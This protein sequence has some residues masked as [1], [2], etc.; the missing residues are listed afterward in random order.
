MIRPINSEQVIYGVIPVGGR[1]TRLRNIIGDVPKV[2]TRFEG[3][4][5]LTYSLLS[6][7]KIGLNQL[8]LITTD[9]THK[10]IIKFVKEF[11]NNY[12]IRDIQINVINANKKGTAKA[13]HYVSHQI[14][15]P[16]FY[17]NG[18][19][20]FYPQIL[21]EIYKEFIS[22]NNLIAVVTGSTKDVAP[23]HPHFVINK[24]CYLTEV[25]I[26]PDIKSST[27][28][29]M[30][31]AIFS[32]EIFNYLEILPENSMTMEAL[33]LAL[34]DGKYVY[35]KVYNNFWYHLA[36]PADIGEYQRCLQEI[37]RIQSILEVKIK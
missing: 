4:E 32:P 15:T 14:K 31:T 21:Q 9:H 13:T 22:N 18:D 27:L 16:F 19:I 10:D 3:I 28:C 2:L 34:N 30:E 36:E 25:C 8:I 35:V 37:R 20:I 6:L 23:T 33:N 17:T 11:K 1:G 7:T 24:D 5:I 12:E 29:S 26:Y